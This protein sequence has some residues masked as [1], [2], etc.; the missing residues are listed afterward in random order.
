MLMLLLLL[1][2]SDT[3]RFGTYIIGCS[4]YPHICGDY[5]CGGSDGTYCLQAYG[6]DGRSL[7]TSASQTY[8]APV[9]IC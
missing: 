2:R 1:T 4:L 7:K 9:R 6:V 5:R 8:L 3:E